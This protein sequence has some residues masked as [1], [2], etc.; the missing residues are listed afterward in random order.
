MQPFSTTKYKRATPQA[1]LWIQDTFLGNRCAFKLN[2]DNKVPLDFQW[3]VLKCI[4]FCYFP[5]L[6][7]KI[8]SLFKHTAI[9][10]KKICKT[11]NWFMYKETFVLSICTRVENCQRGPK[12]TE[13]VSSVRCWSSSEGSAPCFGPFAVVSIC[14]EVQACVLTSLQPQIV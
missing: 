14:L 2:K 4:A 5:F 10:K 1:Y 8:L 7:S 13:K 3:I 11:L 6:I 12:I 9:T